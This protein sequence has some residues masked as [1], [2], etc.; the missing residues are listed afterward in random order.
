MIHRIFYETVRNGVYENGLLE[1]TDT[2]IDN[3][4][5]GE[6]TNGASI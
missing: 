6:M 3:L 5:K 1:M 4:A 2:Q